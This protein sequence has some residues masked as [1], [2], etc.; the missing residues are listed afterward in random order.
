MP[1]KIYGTTLGS[2]TSSGVPVIGCQCPTCLSG[3]SRDKRLRSSIMIECSGKHII[4]DT[5]SDFR[6]QMLRHDVRNIDAILYTHH[7]FDHISGFDDIRALNYLTG[8]PMDC[9]AT[10]Q[11]I[12]HLQR[13]FSYAFNPVV[14]PGG[15]VPVT[16]VHIITPANEF[17]AAGIPVT[18]IPLKHGALDV[19]GFRIGNIAY[20]TDCNAIPEES[21]PLL[22]N[23]DILIIDALRYEKHPTHFTLDEAISVS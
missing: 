13:V 15:G 23:L 10:E 20:C 16:R 6:A 4:I 3:D 2:G 12:G 19:M 7:H 9:Y 17:I 8:E 22:R 11:T 1:E 14:P 5:S 21:F 18:P